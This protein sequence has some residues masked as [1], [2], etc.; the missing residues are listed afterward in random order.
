MT[1]QDILV[2]G[3]LL[4]EVL[5][6][7]WPVPVSLRLVR[8]TRALEA[9][10]TEYNAAR[11]LLVDQY[12]P[13]DAKGDDFKNS[14]PPPE[15][16]AAIEE[17]LAQPVDLEPLTIALTVDDAGNFSI[18]NVVVDGTISASTLLQLEPVINLEFKENTVEQ[19]EKPKTTN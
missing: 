4:N 16:V 15:F 14:T 11:D 6:L 18:N 1:Y 9:R 12:R 8:F 5:A 17:L 19:A 2:A 3:Q 13:K 7:R 10:M